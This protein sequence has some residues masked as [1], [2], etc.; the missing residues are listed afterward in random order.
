MKEHVK[1]IFSVKKIS[2]VE[3]L[4]T[5]TNNIDGNEYYVN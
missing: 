3:Y 1:I 5:N 4:N 2:N